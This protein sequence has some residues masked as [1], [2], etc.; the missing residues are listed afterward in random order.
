[1]S[2]SSCIYVGN[3]GRWT[4]GGY[5]WPLFTWSV[6]GTVVID[7]RPDQH[8]PLAE[9]QFTHVFTTPDMLATMM[10]TAGGALRRNDATRLMVTGGA[11]PATLLAMARQHLTRQV[12]AVLASTEALTVAIT[13]LEQP[14]DLRWHRVHPSREVEVVD[15]SDR[16]LPPGHEG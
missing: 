16:R 13:P 1:M 9:H 15:D 4:A 8:A 2:G 12:F 7:Q 11:L 6:E 14:E 3:F 10:R 5:R